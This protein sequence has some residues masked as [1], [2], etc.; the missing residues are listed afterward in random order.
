M[1]DPISWELAW[2]FYL[3]A[4]LFGYLLGSVPFG[5][6]FTKA[7][8]LGDIRKI[9]SGNIGTTNVLRTGNKKLAAATLLGDGLKGTAAVLIAARF[10]P[11]TAVIAGFGAFLGH[12]FPVWLKFKGGK[13]VATYLGIL[14]G[15]YWPMFL[16]AALTWIGVAVAFRYSS[17]S[18]LIMSAVTP[19]ML[20][21]V[22]SQFQAAEVFLAM[23][24]LLWAKHHEN[25]GRLLKG[26]ES[27]IGS[28]SK[29]AETPAAEP[30][31]GGA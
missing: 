14:L 26:Q 29:A 30:G 2:P 28:K 27:K 25:I 20:Y 7:A 31:S 10:G 24:V 19:V 13:G 4:L 12:L 3:G 16:I 6:L 8:G 21:L 17:L 22:F 11:D 23:T 9:G 15:L 1:P 18:A 5:L